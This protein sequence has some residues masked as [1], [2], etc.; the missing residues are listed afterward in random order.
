MKRAAVLLVLLPRLAFAEPT[1]AERVL[2]TELFK[3]G[4]ALMNEGKFK[5]ACPKL[6]ESQRLDP[7][8]GTVLNLAVC[9]ESEG[10]TAT[11]WTLFHEALAFAKRDGRED[12]RTIA[13]EHI[14]ALQPKLARVRVT[15]D[16][17]STI[18]VTIDGEPFAR[19]AWNDAVPIDPGDHKIEASAPGKKGFVTTIHSAPGETSTVE[20]GAL[21]AE[22]VV[23][24]IAPPPPKKD[25][26]PPASPPPSSTIPTGTWIAGG[27]GVVALGAAGYFSARALGA[28]GDSDDACV[29]GC[30]EEGVIA[31]D[32]AK[33]FADAATVSVVIGVASRATGVAIYV[34]QPR[35]G[36]TVSVTP[37][38]ARFI[39]HF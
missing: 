24:P 32:R 15:V 25:V 39:V 35:P 6:Q 26:R 14:A 34:L 1:D 36:T 28:R 2:A 8:G 21:E 10:R 9:R 23:P 30:T 37:V 17:A 31:N 11:A 16:V 18:T 20:I 22:P 38:G 3:Q 19:A 13:E 7:G 12:R 33:G 4:K 29:K 5:E 27:I